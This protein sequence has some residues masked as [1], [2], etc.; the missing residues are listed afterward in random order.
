MERKF[1]CWQCHKKFMADD[2]MW[3]ECPHCHSDN[4][5]YYSVDYTKFTKW[6]MG[7]TAAVGLAYGAFSVYNT[8]V[9][10]KK[11]TSMGPTTIDDVTMHDSIEVILP[12]LECQPP[13]LSM[14][15]DAPEFDGKAYRF[16][17]RV[18]YPPQEAFKYVLMDVFEDKIISES[19]EGIF[20]AVPYSE[21]EGG[22]YRIALCSEDGNQLLSEPKPIIGFIKQ[23]PVTRR[24]TAQELQSL[25]LTGD[26]S[27]FGVGENDYLAPDLK[28]KYA[29][30]PKDVINVPK[31]LGELY[32]DKILF[33]IWEV[34]IGSVDYDEFNRISVVTLNVKDKSLDFDIDNE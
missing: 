6:A 28:L 7:V 13:I 11:E 20:S 23:Q 9:P 21:A 32:T 12:P 31:T 4:I 19:K 17:I 34:R 27:I 5:E 16:S 30:L 8:Y 1:E 10:E 29:N 24:M 25:L 26:E 2:K 33:E 22:T 14:V 18:E 3:V 15:E